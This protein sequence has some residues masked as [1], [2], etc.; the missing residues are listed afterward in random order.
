M[1]SA[2]GPFTATRLSAWSDVPADWSAARRT[3]FQSAAFLGAWYAT[4]GVRAGSRPVIIDVRQ[5]GAPAMLLPMVYEANGLRALRFADAD[6]A[7]N[8]APL[9]G[10]GAPLTPETFR[11]AWLA[12]LRAMPAADIISIEKQ[13]D[14][15]AGQYNPLRWLGRHQPSPLQSHPLT[16]GGTFEEYSRGRSKKFRK[17]QER[18]WRVF[19]RSPDATFELVAA[20]DRALA[21][22]ADMDRLQSA[23]MADVGANY[24]LDEP[25]Y[26]AFYRA[27]VE[28]GVGHGAVV[29]GALTAADETVAALLGVS[30][31]ESVAFVRLA[32]AGGEWANCSPGRLVIERTLMALHDAGIRQFDFSIGDQHYKE[33]FGVGTAPLTDVDVPVSWRAWPTIAANRARAQLRQFRALRVMYD[34]VRRQRTAA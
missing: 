7:D 32:H 21:I 6:V 3:P 16:I 24:Q 1:R 12:A 34:R 19:T 9:L 18:I 15:I 22:L 14:L 29:L 5:D 26:A 28:L 30:N 13:S 23:R 2:S 10:E 31:G 20:P 27:L 11:L 4:L 8:C 33:P 25:V 17:E